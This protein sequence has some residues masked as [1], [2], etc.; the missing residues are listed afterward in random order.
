MKIVTSITDQPRQNFI[1]GLD[2]NESVE[3]TLY[4]YSSQSAWYYDFKY[5]DYV[6]N[7]NKVV[8][9]MNSL[10]YLRNIIPFGIGFIAGNNADPFYLESF[11][12][13]DCV[14]VIWNKEEVQ[15]LEE[16]IYNVA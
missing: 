12:N 7:G 6:S 5:N 2:N 9:D 14:M 15:E 3:F 13:N 1:V 8:L 16:N 4:F 10:R 11:V